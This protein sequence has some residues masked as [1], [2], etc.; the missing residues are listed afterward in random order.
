VSVALPGAHASPVQ[1]P[2]S[3]LTRSTS[4]RMQTGDEAV[5]QGE[6]VQ[7]TGH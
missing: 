4:S 6:P 3:G 7:M 2:G 5:E 1:L